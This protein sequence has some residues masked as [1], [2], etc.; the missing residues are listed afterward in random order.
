MQQFPRMLKV[1]NAGYSI[2][3]CLSRNSKMIN[4]LESQLFFRK[5]K[6]SNYLKSIVLLTF[7]DLAVSSSRD[8]KEISFQEMS[9]PKMPQVHVNFKDLAQVRRFLI[10]SRYFNPKR[11]IFGENYATLYNRQLIQWFYIKFPVI[12]RV[13]WSLYGVASGISASGIRRRWRP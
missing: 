12:F 6:S 1:I 5:W 10:F 3:W 7:I 13:T 8:L 9:V 2:F 11:F 4:F